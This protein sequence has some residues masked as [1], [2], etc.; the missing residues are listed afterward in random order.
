MLR[1]EAPDAVD[2]E[3]VPLEERIVIADHLDVRFDGRLGAVQSLPVA[4][5]VD[6]AGW[7][8]GVLV[9][10]LHSGGQSWLVD[11]VVLDIVVQPI[12]LDPAEPETVFVSNAVAV[13]SFYSTTQAPAL[14]VVPWS[15]RWTSRVRVVV[16]T[17][18]ED[19]E[20]TEPLLA[21]LSVWLVGRKQR[22]CPEAVADA[23]WGRTEA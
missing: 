8:S 3:D 18:N 14:S 17:F 2:L 9:A 7:V 16:Q 12:A 4:T 21:T 10:I 22:V 23:A 11:N 6:C 13:A 20:G 5:G 15:G 1:I 19:T